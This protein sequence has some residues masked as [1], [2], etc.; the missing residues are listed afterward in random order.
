MG[1]KHNDDYIII[2]TSSLDNLSVHITGI[3]I[4]EGPLYNY[5]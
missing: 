2:E 5:T 3:P 4:S 1:T